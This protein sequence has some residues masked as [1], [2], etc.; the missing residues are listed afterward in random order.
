VHPFI[1]L[2]DLLRSLYAC[3]RRWTRRAGLS[4][5]Q[6]P[7]LRGDT[8][9]GIDPS[10]WVDA[11]YRGILRRSADPEARARWGDFLKRHGP[12]GIKQIC[13]MLIYSEE[14]FVSLSRGSRFFPAYDPVWED[15]ERPRLVFLHILKTAGLSFREVLKTLVGDENVSPPIVGLA[16]VPLA[17][18][19]GKPII[20][21]HTHWDEAMVLIPAREK[22]FITILRRPESRIRSLYR[23]A[24]L[25]DLTQL[26][27]LQDPI[28]MKA[29]SLSPEGF[30]SD[31]EVKTYLREASMTA[32]CMGLRL[33]RAWEAV[34]ETLSPRDAKSFLEE[35]VRPRMRS[36]LREFAF[37]GIQERFED[38]VRVLGRLIGTSPR[39]LVPKVNVTDSL[40]GRPGFREKSNLSKGLSSTLALPEDCLRLDRILYEEGLRLFHELSDNPDLIMEKTALFRRVLG[41]PQ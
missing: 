27:D 39:V 8:C 28:V 6:G 26:E 21:A 31:P 35:E 22:F 41:E 15:W 19:R 29:Q 11:L 9:E 20:H 38:S 7:A 3:W 12:D 10:P 4:Q 14:F 17:I 1:H 16:F 34:L 25:I 32:V 13:K 30:F 18:L 2:R 24:G 33:C 5:T 36:R 37:V 23:Y 40:P